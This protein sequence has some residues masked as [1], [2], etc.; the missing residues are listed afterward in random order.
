MAHP[1]AA[2][3]CRAGPRRPRARIW[4]RPWLPAQCRTTHSAS[5]RMRTRRSTRGTDLSRPRAR[6]APAASASSAPVPAG[7]VLT[8]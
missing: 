6:A 7:K 8:S 3:R 4:D 5:P 1:P 2:A